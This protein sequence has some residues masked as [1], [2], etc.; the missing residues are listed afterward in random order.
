M[1]SVGILRGGLK[2][3]TEFNRPP[4]AALKGVPRAQNDTKLQ[5]VQTVPRHIIS[6]P[7]SFL[8]PKPPSLSFT[9][10]DKTGRQSPHIRPRKTPVTMRVAVAC[11]G[12]RA[13][14]KIGLR[15][16]NNP[17]KRERR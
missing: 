13:Y 4:Q 17:R 6:C 2:I 10:W 8:H 15:T 11:C 3:V 14:Q 1:L 5:G 12:F 16:S 7:G 9:P